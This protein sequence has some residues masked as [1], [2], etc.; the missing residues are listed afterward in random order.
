[1]LSRGL[2]AQDLK[3]NAKIKSCLYKG[4]VSKDSQ[5]QRTKQ[6]EKKLVTLSSLHQAGACSATESRGTHRPDRNTTSSSPSPS[7]VERLRVF[8]EK[9][10]RKQGKAAPSGNNLSARG[11]AAGSRLQQAT[12]QRHPQDHREQAP[13]GGAQDSF[14]SQESAAAPNHL[15]SKEG[16]MD[17]TGHHHTNKLRF[18]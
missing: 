9:W 3:Q 17:S 18:H 1:M 11:K 14:P 7:S 4:T 13:L 6:K 5:T 2:R 12:S 15:V 10:R 16:L 8:G